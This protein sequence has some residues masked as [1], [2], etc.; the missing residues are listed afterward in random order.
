MIPASVADAT[1]NNGI[2]RRAR[3]RVCGCGAIVLVGLDADRCAGEARVDTAPVTA[4]GEVVALLTGR[5]TY[6][7]RTAGRTEIDHRSR[8]HIRGANAD[9]ATVL[10]EHRCHTPPLPTKPAVLTATAKEMPDAPD[11]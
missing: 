10:A 7:L 3:H 2:G 5:A 8:W 4:V 6:L 9:Q 11:F 1:T